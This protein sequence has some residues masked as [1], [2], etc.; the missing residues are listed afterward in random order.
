MD[1]VEEILRKIRELI[2]ENVFRDLYPKQWN[3]FRRMFLDFIEAIK[4]N[5]PI[6]VKEY[7]GKIDSFIEFTKEILLFNALDADTRQKIRELLV[8]LYNVNNNS[9]KDEDIARDI[10]LCIKIIDSCLTLNE[11]IGVSRTVIT[12]MRHTLLYSPPA[13]ELAPHYLKTM[14]DEIEHDNE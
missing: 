3:S 9:D 8:F 5:K 10:M 13:F 7:K 11:L 6:S 14:L 2:D 12:K 1:N 4:S